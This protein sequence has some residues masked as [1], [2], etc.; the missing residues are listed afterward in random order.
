M[1]LKDEKNS[2]YKNLKSSIKLNVHIYRAY[3]K[4]QMKK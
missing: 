4:S 1:V 3:L 2:T